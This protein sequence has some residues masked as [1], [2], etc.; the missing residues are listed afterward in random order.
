M[1][2]DLRLG[3]G[4]DSL[5]LKTLEADRYPLPRCPDHL[6]QRR[7]AFALEREALDDA[8]R[9][10][11][12]LQ[13]QPAQHLAGKMNEAA[14]GHRGAG[15]QMQA[16]SE[17]LR[18]AD[19]IA[20]MPVSQGNFAP[21]RRGIEHPH[22]ALLDQIDAIMR[23]ALREQHLTAADDAPDTL[24]QHFLLLALVQ[25]LEQGYWATR[26]LFIFGEQHRT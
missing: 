12:N 2:H 7:V 24:R 21:R 17:H 22:P 1:N 10:A 8:D 16:R 3:R 15:P 18:P 11:R 23:G 6:R 20:L 5:F 25:L 9:Q 14:V 26:K 19:E 13:H 4:K